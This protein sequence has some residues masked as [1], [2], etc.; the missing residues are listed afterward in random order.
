MAVYV[1]EQLCRLSTHNMQVCTQKCYSNV[2]K[3]PRKR[4]ACQS[5]NVHITWQTLIINLQSYIVLG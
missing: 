5:C 2:A 1:Y 3:L 4:T